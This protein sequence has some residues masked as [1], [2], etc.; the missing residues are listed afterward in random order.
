MNKRCFYFILI[1]IFIFINILFIRNVYAANILLDESESSKIYVNDKTEYL[2]K[3]DNG[4]VTNV[5]GVITEAFTDK[6]R[7]NNIN[8]KGD[9]YHNVS[10]FEYVLKYK[11]YSDTKELH[12][13]MENI[14]MYDL[15]GNKLGELTS[16][17]WVVLDPISVPYHWSQL[18][19]EH[20]NNR[21]SYGGAKID[22]RTG[23]IISI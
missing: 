13:L 1:P 9:F 2:Y 4:N 23:K 10:K 17:E 6:G 12:C 3:S 16:D 22:S 20:I 8:S 11:Y 15:N 5:S 7:E 19:I 18:I 21:I 14:F